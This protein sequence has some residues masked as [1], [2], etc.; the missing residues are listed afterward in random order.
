M[1]D[2]RLSGSNQ[3][4]HVCFV[5]TYV[6]KWLGGGSQQVCSFYSASAFKRDI[7][8]NERTLEG[9]KFIFAPD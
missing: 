2:F 5:H 7:Y 3:E 1:H 8:V 9:N 6:M 4:I